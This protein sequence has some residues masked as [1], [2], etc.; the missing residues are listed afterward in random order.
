M[1]EPASNYYSSS[2]Y[3]WYI[4]LYRTATT[5]KLILML[6]I[7]YTT[8]IG[9]VYSLQDAVF[10]CVLKVNCHFID[11]FYRSLNQFMYWMRRQATKKGKKQCCV[12]QTSEKKHNRKT[13]CLQQL[14]QCISHERTCKHWKLT[15]SYSFTIKLILSLTLNYF[16]HHSFCS[17]VLCEFT[18]ANLNA[19]ICVQ[20]SNFLLNSKHID[21]NKPYLYK[22]TCPKQV[23]MF[24][25]CFS[26]STPDS[27]DEFRLFSADIR[28]DVI[29]IEMSVVT[30]VESSVES[31]VTNNSLSKDYLHADYHALNK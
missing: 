10:F 21:Q 28:K 5:L 16:Y 3:A 14:P 15:V 7:F 20:M 8:V 30:S 18:G 9:A 27:S 22:V 19:V 2:H 6:K 1:V 25:W 13:C 11:T 26:Y 17:E 24:I 29:L 23:K 31:S 4:R 12:T